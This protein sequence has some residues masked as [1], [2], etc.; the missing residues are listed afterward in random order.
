MECLR[1]IDEESA[2]IIDRWFVSTYIWQFKIYETNGQNN[3]WNFI[4]ILILVIYL[5]LYVC[6]C[7]RVLYLSEIRRTCR[8]VRK[9]TGSVHMCYTLQWNRTAF[10]RTSFER[11][12][13]GIN[14][15][16]L[17][18]QLA[19]TGNREQRDIKVIIIRLSPIP[20]PKFKLKRDMRWM[21]THSP[22]AWLN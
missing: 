1:R 10:G 5:F 2:M 20:V 17:Q 12:I 13:K 9:T 22:K 4:Y 3:M 19:F 15:A 14:R 16:G 21:R 8:H 7:V 18:L 6:V 11:E